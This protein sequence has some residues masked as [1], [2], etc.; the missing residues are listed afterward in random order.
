MGFRLSH[1]GAGPFWEGRS[2]PRPVQ[3]ESWMELNAGGE[4]M[5]PGAVYITRVTVGGAGCFWMGGSQKVTLPKTPL[6][7]LCEGP[8][9]SR[10]GDTS[11]TN[12]SNV[13]HLTGSP[14]V[15]MENILVSVGQSYFLLTWSWGPLEWW[16]D[17]MEIQEPPP[18]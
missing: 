3:P 4:N 7:N 5:E 12:H 18:R 17:N 9:R 10:S 1:D 16:E 11:D 8:H 14:S 6:L 2:S 15:S 13:H